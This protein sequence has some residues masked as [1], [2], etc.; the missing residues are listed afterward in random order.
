MSSAT[1]QAAL[2]AIKVFE[3]AGILDAEPFGAMSWENGTKAAN[4]AVSE[5]GE[6]EAL[7]EVLAHL[8][9]RNKPPQ[10]I[11]SSLRTTGG[12]VGN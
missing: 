10:P 1:S 5:V 8:Q 3:V 4:F 7:D 6:K 11:S 12:S 2:K 9:I